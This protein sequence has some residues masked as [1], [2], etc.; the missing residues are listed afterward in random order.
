M[1]ERNDLPRALDLDRA[2]ERLALW[3]ARTAESAPGLVVGLSGTDSALAFLACA[4][5][6]KIAGKAKEGIVG[7]HYGETF[8]FKEWFS[9]RGSVEVVPL[10]R[11]VGLDADAYRWAALQ[12]YALKRRFWIVG[13][14]NRTEQAL[15]DYSN[16]SSVAVM[17]PLVAFWKSEVFALCE[18]L[19]VPKRLVEAG[20]MGDP[21]CSC[22][23]PGLLGRLTDCETVLAAR[24]GELD[25]KAVEAEASYDDAARF[26]GLFTEGK[27]YKSKIPYR[28]PADLL[29]GVIIRQGSTEGA[30]IVQ[31]SAS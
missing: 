20:W 4:K 18:R 5:A 16:A 17:Q 29:D 31:R 28:P 10:R 6:W 25:A 30:D 7:I 21:E 15:G 2:F 22:H 8:E 11:D 9:E 1:H 27:T 3:I 13:T 26:L 23:R 19:G 24:L 14:R 12:T